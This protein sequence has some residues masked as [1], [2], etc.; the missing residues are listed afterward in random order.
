MRVYSAN[1]KSIIRAPFDDRSS[2]E[3][4]VHHVRRILTSIATATLVVGGVRDADAQAIGVQQPVVEQFGVSTVVSVP[5][6]GSALLGSVSSSGTFHRGRGP[7]DVGANLSRQQRH[8][9]LSTH[10]WIHDFEAMDAAL[11]AEGRENSPVR[12]TR[13]SPQSSLTLMAAAARDQLLKQHEQIAR[14][15]T[16][17]T[18]L[19]SSTWRVPRQA[20][21][22]EQVE[23]DHAAAG[24]TVRRFGSR[25][26]K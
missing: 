8:G 24:S 11:L 21:A 20:N 26:F 23:R 16:M 2:E 3:T 13:G 22:V 19:R 14:R 9:S 7:L 15:R 5:D 1:L 25:T 18:N 6:R 17:P 4:S 10:V 12:I